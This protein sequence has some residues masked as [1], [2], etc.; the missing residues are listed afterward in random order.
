MKLN[1]AEIK[2]YAKSATKGNRLPYFLIGLIGYLATFGITFTISFV[3]GLLS[4]FTGSE[5]FITLAS[6]IS[7]IVTIFMTAGLQMS[8]M[9]AGL[10]IYDTSHCDTSDVW[11]GYTNLKKA[12]AVYL[13]QTIY[14][15]LWSLLFVV[16]GIIK[17]YEYSQAMYVAIDNPEMSSGDCLRRSKELMKGHKFELFV[18]GLSFYG[19]ALLGTL[20]CGILYIWLIPYMQATYAGFYRELSK[21]IA[22]P[23]VVTGDMKIH[24]ESEPV[25]DEFSN[26]EPKGDYTE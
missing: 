11:Y 4:G 15:T 5:M 20:T 22:D 13:K 18:W 10:N 23:K 17:A 1:R 19:W 2:Q 6:V 9:Y 8:Y 12:A 24:T 16:P 3:C 21:N 26:T 14:T 25:V 7:A